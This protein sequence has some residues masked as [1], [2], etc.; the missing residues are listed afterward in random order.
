MGGGG[1]VVGKGTEWSEGTAGCRGMR[2]EGSTGEHSQHGRRRGGMRTAVCTRERGGVG[3]MLLTAAS[4]FTPHAPPL[5]T[6]LPH[7]CRKNNPSPVLPLP[8]S[9]SPSL[10]PCLP[11]RPTSSSAPSVSRSLVQM[12]GSTRLSAGMCDTREKRKTAASRDRKKERA[13]EKKKLPTLGEGWGGR[14]GYT[15]T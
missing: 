3:C 11:A 6:T 13:P 7:P 12:Q 2:Q 10:P 5:L 1:G 9:P 8:L 14:R 15:R 4:S